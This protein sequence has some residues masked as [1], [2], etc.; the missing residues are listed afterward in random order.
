MLESLD[1]VAAA[2]EEGRDEPGPATVELTVRSILPLIANNALTGTRG[3]D[4]NDNSDERPPA[5]VID[6]MR[7]TKRGVRQLGEV[8]RAYADGEKS[9]RAIDAAGNDII[10]H[11]PKNP[12]RLGD[13][14]LREEYPDPGKVATPK[15]SGD[16]PRDIYAQ[17]IHDLQTAIERLDVLRGQ[18]KACHEHNGT[19]LTE[20]IGVDYRACQK[21]LGII[22]DFAKDLAVWEKADINYNGRRHDDTGDDEVV[23]NENETG[24]SDDDDDG[25][26]EVESELS[27]PDDQRSA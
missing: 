5:L 7:H 17:R 1:E 19:V 16:Q 27:Q 20:L 11:D 12:V 8:L 13:V 2:K 22:N 21:W 24:E 23:L 10:G 26:Q 3:F 4:R 14:Y 6:A 9:F 25:D 18:V 15:P